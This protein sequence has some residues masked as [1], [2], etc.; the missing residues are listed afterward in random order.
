MIDIPTIAVSIGDPAGVGPEVT[1]KALLDDALRNTARW[2]LVGEDWQIRTLGETL[3]FQPDQVVDCPADMAKDATV[4]VLRAR[5][6]P[7]SELAVGEVD[8][9]GVARAAGADEMPPPLGGIGEEP[10]GQ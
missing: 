6:L 10:T 3:G 2:V 4:V 9:G 5:Q 7:E 1:I 8:A